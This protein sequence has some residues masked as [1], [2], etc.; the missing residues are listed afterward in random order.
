MISVGYI[1]LGMMSMG[2]FIYLTTA[3]TL[4]D[5][6]W[7]IAPM[8]AVFAFVCF[9]MI[10]VNAMNPKVDEAGEATKAWRKRFHERAR[11]RG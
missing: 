11:R 2:V 9:A 8:W 5:V 10:A 7:I 4:G 6:Q 1:F 3:T